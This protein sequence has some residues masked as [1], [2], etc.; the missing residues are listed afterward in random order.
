M[1]SQDNMFILLVARPCSNASRMWKGRPPPGCL[2]AL[3]IP[4]L[5]IREHRSQGKAFSLSPHMHTPLT[6]EGS[7]VQTTDT[8]SDTLPLSG[9]WAAAVGF[10]SSRAFLRLSS[11]QD[12]YSCR[13]SLPC[14]DFQCCASSFVWSWDLYFL[15]LP[16]ASVPSRWSWRTLPAQEPFFHHGVRPCFFRPFHGPSPRHVVFSSLGCEST[17]VSFLLCLNFLLNSVLPPMT[18]GPGRPIFLGLAHLWGT[19]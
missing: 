15:W 4:T 3:W 13:D 19:C 18:Q 1:F 10:L 9:L 6:A 17:S 7:R 5:G 16:L 2:L 11:N 8:C 12:I 14:S